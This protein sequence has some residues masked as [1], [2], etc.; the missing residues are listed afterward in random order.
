MDLLRWLLIGQRWSHPRIDVWERQL[1]EGER[2]SLRIC[3]Q[4][5]LKEKYL[6]VSRG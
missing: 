2:V 5:S 1:K 3:T 6:L 4:E